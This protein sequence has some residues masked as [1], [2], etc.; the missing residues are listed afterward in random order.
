MEELRLKLAIAGKPTI[1]NTLDTARS[2]SSHEIQNSP[3]G[4]ALETHI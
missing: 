4:L 2:E 3:I 1:L